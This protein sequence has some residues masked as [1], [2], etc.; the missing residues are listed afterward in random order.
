MMTE[1]LDDAA[2]TIKSVRTKKKGKK[3]RNST[4]RASAISA[5]WQM[6]Q[7]MV[8]DSMVEDMNETMKSARSGRSGKSKGKKK[9]K[10]SRASSVNKS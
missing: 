8:D 4:L 9:K 1:G 10:G 5:Q 2:E 3:R 6:N 7:N